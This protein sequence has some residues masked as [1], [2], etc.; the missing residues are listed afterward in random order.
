MCMQITRNINDEYL[1]MSMISRHC[2]KIVPVSFGYFCANYHNGLGQVRVILGA[3]ANKRD[4]PASE[5]L[6]T[7]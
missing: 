3:R 6:E 7:A 2:I 5:T 1:I 4:G